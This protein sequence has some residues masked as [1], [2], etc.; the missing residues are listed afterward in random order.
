[1]KS[2]YSWFKCIY[3]IIYN[4]LQWSQKIT[5]AQTLLLVWDPGCFKMECFVI[6]AV[7]N[8]RCF[9]LI[10]VKKS[11]DYDDRIINQFKY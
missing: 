4:W 5:N 8:S 9:L 1:M 6:C 11:C 10:L 7:E 3:L 2:Y